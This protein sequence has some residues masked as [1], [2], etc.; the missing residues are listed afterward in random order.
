MAMIYS[1]VH[2]S[3]TCMRAQG[4]QSES[5]W[6]GSQRHNIVLIGRALGRALCQSKGVS[7]VL[8]QTR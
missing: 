7:G 3:R 4:Q 1:L 8:I 2:K 5:R 6:I